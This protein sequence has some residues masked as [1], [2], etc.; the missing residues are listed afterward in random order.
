M[1]SQRAGLKLITIKRGSNPSWVTILCY[2]DEAKKL[3][4]AYR[5]TLEPITAD[6]LLN[7]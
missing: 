1:N 3:G 2:L 4:V 7:N 5:M 6:F